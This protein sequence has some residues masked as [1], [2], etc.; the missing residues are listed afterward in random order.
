VTRRAPAPPSQR[1]HFTP[2]ATFDLAAVVRT[3]G[4]VD[5]A[6]WR[7]AAGRLTRRERIAGVIGELTVRQSAP[8]RVIATWRARTTPAGADVHGAVRAVVARALSWDWDTG[9]VLALAHALDP[10]AADLLA[11]GGGRLLRGTTFYED[12]AKTVCTINTSWAGTV[13]MAARLVE[14]VGRGAFPTPGAVLRFGEARL[15]QECRLGFRAATLHRGTARLL[16][17][18]A[19]DRAGH[20]AAATLGYDYL[21]SLFGIGPYAAAHCRVLLHDFSRLPVDSVVVAHARDRLG[22]ARDAV[23]AHFARWGDYRFL[24]YRLG[25]IA[26]R[27]AADRIDD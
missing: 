18:G 22:L 3:H 2:P 20:G 21:V 5:L 15:R 23:E 26:A 24:G 8:S 16:A 1:W 9:T 19:I 12:F 25:R 17:D 6:P 10:A 27:Q 13:A 14:R 7:W 4:W 11:R